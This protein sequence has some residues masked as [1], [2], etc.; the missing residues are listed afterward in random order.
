[1]NMSFVVA[2]PDLVEAAAQDLAG[3]RYAL[4]EATKP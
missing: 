4:D 3:I 1:M 2:V